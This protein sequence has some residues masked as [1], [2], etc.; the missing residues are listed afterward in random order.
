[1]PLSENLIMRA[2]ALHK[3]IVLAEGAEERT[4]SAARMIAGEGMAKVTLVGKESAI[5]AA[6]PEL[7]KLGITAVEPEKSPKYRQYASEFYEMRKEKGMTPE[8]ALELMKDEVYFATMMVKAGDADGMVAGAIHTTGETLRPALQVIKTAPGISIVSSIFLMELPKP[9]Y[10]YNGVFI[11]A[12]CALIVNPSAKELASIAIAAARSGRAL[13]GMEPRVA[14][15]SFSTKGS[16]KHEMVD[17]VVEATRIAKEM[18]PT[19]IIDGEL[20][21]D[22]ALVASVGLLKS[23]GSPVA[24]KANVLIFPDLNSGNIAYKLVQRLAGAVAMG[25]I[26]QGLAKP[27]NDLSRGCVPR[28]IVTV[29]AIT[30][31]QANN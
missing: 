2:K 5:R 4:Q 15:L 3:H 27:V 23:P 26:T 25:P 22:A 1:M 21:A 19:L 24:G 11:F 17:K 14:M 8:E 20:Q 12:D 9:E 10:G 29:A 31:L 6:I 30:A 16:A 18:D 13:T 7:D 28:D